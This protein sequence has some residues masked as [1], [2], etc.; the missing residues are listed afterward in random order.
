MFD[1]RSDGGAAGQPTP[2]RRANAESCSWFVVNSCPSVKQIVHWSILPNDRPQ[3]ANCDFDSLLEAVAM[4]VGLTRTT[5][6]NKSRPANR[7]HVSVQRM[8]AEREC[9]SQNHWLQNHPMG[10]DFDTARHDSVL[11]DS[12]KAFLS[13]GYGRFESRIRVLWQRTSRRPAMLA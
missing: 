4:A 1:F 7:C 13:A 5:R 6:S 8:G 10:S 12:V 11:H 9:E 3:S 2:P